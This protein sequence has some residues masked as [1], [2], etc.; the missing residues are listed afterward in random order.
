MKKIILDFEI[1][2]ITLLPKIS[3]CTLLEFRKFFPQLVPGFYNLL[4]LVGRFIDYVAW[5][6]LKKVKNGHLAVFFDFLTTLDR[7]NR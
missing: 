6:M 1:D 5:K 3:N 4:I 7:Y 2:I